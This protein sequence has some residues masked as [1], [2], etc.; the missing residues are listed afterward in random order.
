MIKDAAV[1]A[2]RDR[3]SG[4]TKRTFVKL[5]MSLCCDIVDMRSLSLGAMNLSPAVCPISVF[6]DFS[7]QNSGNSERTAD[8]GAVLAFTKLSAAQDFRGEGGVGG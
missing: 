2:I 6:W 8:A 7:N 3:N 1:V 4:R 5:T